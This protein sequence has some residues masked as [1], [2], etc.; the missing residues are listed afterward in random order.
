MSSDLRLFRISIA[1]EVVEVGGMGFGM[2]SATQ[3]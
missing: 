3:F 2:K 1:S